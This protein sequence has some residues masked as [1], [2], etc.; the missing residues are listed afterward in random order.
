MFSLYIYI[1]ARINLNNLLLFN[2]FSPKK[3]I[4]KSYSLTIEKKTIYDTCIFFQLFPAIDTYI[5]LL[6]SH[7][8]LKIHKFQNIISKYHMFTTH[9]GAPFYAILGFNISNWGALNSVF[10]I[11]PTREIKNLDV[12]RSIISSLNLNSV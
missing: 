6:Q 9:I 12:R 11:A 2:D 4:K 3:G 1:Y 7:N 8:T 10:H 5:F